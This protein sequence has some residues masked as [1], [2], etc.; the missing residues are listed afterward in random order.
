MKIGTGWGIDGC[1]GGPRSDTVEVRGAGVDHGLDEALVHASLNQ[2]EA[3]VGTPGLA[4][5]VLD[6]PIV[7]LL[8]IGA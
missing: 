4:P 2:E 6:D 7:A 1:D 5:G 3:A 8:G